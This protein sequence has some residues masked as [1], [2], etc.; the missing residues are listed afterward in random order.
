MYKDYRLGLSLNQLSVVN[1]AELPPLKYG[2]CAAVNCAYRMEVRQLSRPTLIKV[3]EGIYGVNRRS[4][5]T[6]SY[7]VESATGVVLIDAG[8]HSSGGD[9]EFALASIGRQPRDV[10][11]VLLTH[12]HNDHS[13]GAVMIRAASGARVY[14]HERE[15]PYFTRQTAS[16][17]LAGW[18][19]D[20]IPE[21][22]PLILFKGLL[23]SAPTNAVQATRLVRE[24]DLIENDFEV[25]ETPGHTP[26]HVSYYHRPTRT[27]F[28]GDAL[29]VI[30]GRLRFMA[31][32]VT[33]D[34]PAARSSILRCLDRPIE[35]ICPGHRQPLT[36]NVPAECD[37]IR[38]VIQRD[39]RWPLFG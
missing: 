20:H 8:M 19:S 14:Y 9:L 21:T 11:A 32:P 1:W 7:A 38:Q 37:R 34:L 12:W 23:G 24:G 29:A 31:R 3:R 13:A 26:G 6:C 39:D 10:Q 15:Q 30:N 35:C 27:L 4:Y 18:L 28:A 17:G 33:P 36:S 25:I 2:Q 5:F 16:H 22:G